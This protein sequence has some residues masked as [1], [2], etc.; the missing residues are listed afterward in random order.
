MLSYI[1][2]FLVLI[3][4]V[5]FIHEYG[6][7]YFARKYGVGVTD[8]SIGFGKELFGWNDKHGTRWKICAIPLGGYVK[9]FGDRNVYSQADHKEI[10]EKYSKEEQEKLFILKPLYQR[11]LIVFGGDTENYNAHPY[12]KLPVIKKLGLTKIQQIFSQDYL[13]TF[14][15]FL[16]CCLEELLKIIIV[17]I[18]FIKKR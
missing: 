10:L 3:L 13:N 2:P 17:R 18:F 14:E 6:H 16:R 8:F 15:I 5:V 1:V 7:Y 4:V 9:F 11:V 12:Q